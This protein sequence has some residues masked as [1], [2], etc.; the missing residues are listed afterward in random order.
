MAKD[1]RIKYLEDLLIQLGYNPS[2]IAVAETLVRRKN[3]IIA[4]LRRQ[5]KMPVTEDLMANEIE[6]TET[7][8]LEIM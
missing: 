8:K 2:N 5:L 1:S 3:A 7:R 4:S 6:E